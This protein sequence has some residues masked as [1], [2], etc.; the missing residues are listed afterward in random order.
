[1]RNSAALDSP[2]VTDGVSAAGKKKPRRMSLLGL[3]GRTEATPS[4]GG[5]P[6]IAHAVSAGAPR[7]GRMSVNVGVALGAQREGSFAASLAAAAAAA[8]ASMDSSKHAS[9][10]GEPSRRSTGRRM[11]VS[12][13]LRRVSN[14]FAGNKGQEQPEEEMGSALPSLTR[15]PLP[16]TMPLP[17]TWRTLP[18]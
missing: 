18:G 15:P 4:D 12:R 14:L 2:R 6:P 5:P 16:Q 3:M 13:G 11:S 17:S 8:A 1:M 7:A 10:V 9:E